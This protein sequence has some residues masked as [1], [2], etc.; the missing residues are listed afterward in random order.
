M[1]A[2]RALSI[3]GRWFLLIAILL[4]GLAWVCNLAVLQ[5]G[6]SVSHDA[7]RPSLSPPMP[8]LAA[9]EPAP[10]PADVPEPAADRTEEPPNQTSAEEVIT[11]TQ[12]CVY[13]M[14]MLVTAYCPCRRCCGRFA[15]GKTASGRRTTANGSVFVAADTRLLP[16]GTRVSV[17]G[18][19]GGE[20]APVFDRG[21]RI[22][23]RR[24]DVFFRSHARAK[25]WGKRWLNVTVYEN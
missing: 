2:S 19:Y 20:P 18:Y 6:D 15:D 10:P 12:P 25:R 21:R 11:D 16:F 9:V 4:A 5:A 1:G 24:L 17:P 13:S 14:R 7:P 23:G 22:K 3:A 8:M